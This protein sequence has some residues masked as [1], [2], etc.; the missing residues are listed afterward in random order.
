MTQHF[1]FKTECLNKYDQEVY[2]A[3]MDSFDCL[4]LAALVDDKILAVHGGLIQSMLKF[5]L[6]PIEKINRFTEIVKDKEIVDLLWS[7][8]AADD[9]VSLA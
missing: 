3:I 8:P 2:N 4:P 6:D 1:N 7:D 5:G 9:H